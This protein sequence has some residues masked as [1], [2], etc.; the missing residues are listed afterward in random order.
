MFKY[1]CFI[2]SSLKCVSIQPENN[3]SEAAIIKWLKL[4]KLKLSNYFLNIFSGP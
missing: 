3:Q 2:G 1:L 4:L